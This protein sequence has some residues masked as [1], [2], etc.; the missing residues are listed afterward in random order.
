MV[1]TS[2]AFFV[3]D[4]TT[5]EHLC[6]VTDQVADTTVVFSAN[7]PYLQVDHDVRFDVDFEVDHEIYE[8]FFGFVSLDGVWAEHCC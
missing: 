4:R 2:L 8:F 3:V 7:I 5:E 1:W 6:E